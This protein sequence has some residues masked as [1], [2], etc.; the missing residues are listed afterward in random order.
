MSSNSANTAVRSCFIAA[1][2]YLSVAMLPLFI[3][4]CT[5]HLYPDQISG[6]TQL[7]LPNMVLAHTALPIQILFFGSLLSAIMSTTSSALL[8]P[9]AV[10]SENL[11]KPLLKEKMTDKHFLLLTRFSI[12]L[13]GITATAM[14]CLRSNIYELVGESSILSL[15]SL[16]APLITGLYWKKA[17]GT[18]AI[19][20][21]VSGLVTWI[22]FEFIYKISIPSLVPATL[23]SF[24]G[25]IFGSLVLKDKQETHG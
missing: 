2:L 9:A 4:L 3:S 13:F 7:T 25:L 15:I 23:V 12:L 8:A 16:F 19:L 1:G 14:A 17:N 22:V 21:M 11:V 10:F 18:G 6:D 20:A 24:I 5:Q